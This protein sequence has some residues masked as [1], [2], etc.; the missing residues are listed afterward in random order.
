MGLFGVGLVSCEVLFSEG[1]FELRDCVWCCT[2]WAMGGEGISFGGNLDWVWLLWA[3][4]N[5]CTVGP[6][7]LFQYLNLN[8]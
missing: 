5:C 7:Y 8:Y 3:L 4:G 2:S 1:T 6:A